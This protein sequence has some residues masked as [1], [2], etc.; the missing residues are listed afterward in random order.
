MQ[1]Y[2]AQMTLVKKLTKKSFEEALDMR[3]VDPS[4]YIRMLCEISVRF[5]F[6]EMKKQY[7][8]NRTH[9][10]TSTGQLIQECNMEL[11]RQVESFTRKAQSYT[12]ESYALWRKT[13]KNVVGD[14]MKKHAE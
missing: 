12:V 7:D 2:A 6:E 14:V 3:R 11:M 8:E 4:V 10:Q 5:V 1:T 13:L 9:I